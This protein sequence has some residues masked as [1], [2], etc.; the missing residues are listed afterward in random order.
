MQRIRYGMVGGGEGAFIGAVHR[1]AARLDD[2]WELV[3]GAFSSSAGKSHRSGVALG[4]PAARCYDDFESMM[5]REASL[6]SGERMQC[7][8]IVTP[9]RTHL[10]I[11]R[12]ALARG[13]HVLSDKPATATLAECQELAAALS[14][15]KLHYGLT[16]PYT[17]YPMIREAR[18]RIARGEL[19]TVRKV[20]VEYMQG[21]LAAPIENT[22]QKQAAWRVD[23]A[24][25]GSSCCMGDIGVHAFQLAEFVSGLQV[26]KICADLHSVVP[27]RRLD[28]DGAVLLRFGGG[29]SG[30]LMASQVCTGEENNL[31]LRIYGEKAGI[32]WNQMEPNSMWFR[33]INAPAQLLRT[34][35]AGTGADAA[36]AQRTPAGHPEGYIEAFANIYREF[37]AQLG[38]MEADT[39]PGITDA[40]RGMSFI[41]TAVASSAAGGQWRDIGG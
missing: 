9:N 12:A 4:L 31:R 7:V 40:L 37:A 1:M 17:A 30:V 18:S 20:L 14:T 41:E 21:W 2:A 39:V 5:A 26:Q 15:S 28:D 29:A 24:E 27:G 33:P 3:C 32:D 23:P 19:G 6:P 38:G 8:V 11:A 13:F 22:G 35:I 16:H 36:A 34:G 10:P 25:A